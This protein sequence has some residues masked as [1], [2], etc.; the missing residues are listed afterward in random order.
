[1]ALVGCVGDDTGSGGTTTG[2][3]TI[4]T[5]QATSS[6][7]AATDPSTSAD[8][9]S[10]GSMSAGESTTAESTGVAT[11]SDATT[12][13]ATD[14]TTDAT[15]SGG[16]LPCM[17]GECPDGQ[18]C[19]AVSEQCAPGCDG[20]EDCMAPTVCDVSTNTCQ[21]C[22]IDGNCALG[23]ICAGGSCVPGCNDQQPCQDGLACCGGDCVDLMSSLDHCGGCDAACGG[24][25]NAEPLCSGACVLGPCK[26]GYSDC[27]K[28]QGNG[29][30]VKGAC[31]CEPG[32]K[33]ECFTGD[34]EA[35]NV[36]ICKAGEATCNAQGTDYGPC[37]GELL[38]KPTDL[39]SN[40]LDDNCNG[41]VDE[42]PDADKDG[43]TVCNGDCCDS[44]GLACNTPELV[45]PGAF[46]FGGNNVDD[47]CDGNKDNVVSLCDAGLA[48]N[49]ASALDY[50]R[51]IDLCQ[52]TTENPPLSQKKWGVI[53]GALTLAD[54]AGA[55]SANARS[56]RPLF[57]GNNPPKMGQRLAVLSSGHAAATGQTNPAFA[58]FQEGVNTGTVSAAP[59]DWLAL[60]GG[61]FPN[62][63]G[64]PG[65]AGNTAFNPVQLKLRVRVPTN[66]KSF[67][68]KMFFYSAEYPEYV[69][70]AF[71]DL[72]V[73]LVDSQGA[74]NP[75]DKNIAVYKQGNLTW[76]VGVNLVKSA[77]G[78]FT[79]CQNGTIGQCGA[80]STYNGCQSTLQVIGT[81]FDVNASAC[82]HFGHSG[83]GTGW[84]TMSGNVK[85]GE[86]MEIRFTIW[87]TGDQFWDSVVLLDDWQ[88]SVQAAQPG[89]Q[90]G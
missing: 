49:S 48:S 17:A 45:N 60:N 63:P 20:D 57:G 15:T 78:L 1:M 19:D 32:T 24:L 89:V 22:V 10:A 56:I 25:P 81:G 36:G 70:T 72:F 66:A 82:G 75:P 6:T 61:N 90:P 28:D 77:P 9:T 74:G 47:D 39:C 16:V 40:G 21:G 18:F 68:A 8:S 65:A 62:A 53:S 11:D 85:G 44:P 51:A 23:T 38:P 27:D 64:C 80:P 84:L 43:W 88:W 3:A 37:V 69:C 87:D 52:F 34:A 2:A 55:P 41:V 29:C 26:P 13:G 59:A 35:K 54:G 5:A 73:T 67:S 58:A 31:S 4:T 76:P 7:S 30:E 79:Q 50:A 42:D 12:S 71:N 83:G 14:A 86:T 33:I 46:E